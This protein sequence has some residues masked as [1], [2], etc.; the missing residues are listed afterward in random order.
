MAPF[1]PARAASPPGRAAPGGGAASRIL[2][3]WPG[4]ARFDDVP[5][6]CGLIHRR[7][8]R[9]A[10]LYPTRTRIF[11]HTRR[12]PRE[13][14]A[15]P[16]RDPLYS[17]AFQRFRYLLGLYREHLGSLLA[18]TA[19]LGVTLWM[20]L[21]IPRYLQEAIDLLTASLAADDP[22]AAAARADEVFTRVWIILAFAVAMVLTRTASRMLFFTPGR[23]VEFDL[24]NRLLAH[25]L[26][27]DREF[28]L[29][30]PTGELISRIN[31]DVNGVRMLVGMGT[32]MLF[33]TAA[34]LTLAP[35]Y[36]YRISPELTLYCAIPIA[37]GFFV[38]Q[39]AVKRMR[40]NQQR[41]MRSMQG[42]SDFT[43][44]SYSGLDPLKSFRAFAWAERSFDRLSGDVRD[45]GLGMTT[46]RAWF[47]PLL[48]HLMNALKVLL[49]L[50]GGV[51]VVAGDMTIG[52]F[53]AFTVYL[54]MLAGPLMGATFMMFLLQRG[55]TSLGSLLEVFAGESSRPA[56]RDG[57]TL[58]ARL[59]GGL[60][61]RELR[62]AYPDDPGRWVLDGVSLKVA[63]GE[64]VGIFG[65]IGSG[66]STLVNLL[67]HY[68]VPPEGAVRLDGVDVRDVES[69]E[70][71]RHVVTVMQE[72]FLFSD[73]IRENV[74][75]GA[76]AEECGAEA[77]AEAGGGTG[78]ELA[79][80]DA[81]TDA[82]AGADDE[83]SSVEWAADA[84]ALGSDLARFP[85]GL[86]TLVGERGVT[87]S[88]GQKQR[89]ALARAF[90]RPCDLLVLDDVLSAVDHETERVLVERIHALT[91]ARSMLIVSNRISVL[92]RA[93][94]VVVLDRGRVVD[95]GTHDE[96]A[97]RAGP[98]REA[99][100]RQAHEAAAEEVA[101]A[102]GG[103]APEPA[104]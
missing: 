48:A 44:E 42:L 7:A 97:A 91:K 68:L 79:V 67:N 13:S 76:E 80:A 19:F 28:F 82:G 104:T 14:P 41:Q 78:T 29:A 51:A 62:Y 94:R 46:V 81:G 59:T 86:E 64:V 84:A 89:V 88:G 56:P 20:A 85:S 36:M 6:W 71:R 103:A 92:E 50:V 40:V 66:K 39:L 8:A 53:T 11:T 12:R 90:R 1:H 43:V 26:R 58:P 2:A 83:A 60:E 16:E 101:M 24:K 54:S 95:V 70:V 30:N 10:D 55:M 38:L 35:W 102:S 72:P 4:G 61:V 57:A 87:L 25:L 63:P 73:T 21:A 47:M 32:M 77:V 34:T 31:N 52:D 65:P 5:G 75:F 69:G 99:W 22:A 45:A 49:V 93:D 18:G 27:Q 23:R 9:P 37:I 15:P 33:Q 17:T 3:P 96:L 98:Y 74:A 100:L